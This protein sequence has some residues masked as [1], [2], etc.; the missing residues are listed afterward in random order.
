MPAEEP[1]VD[2]PDHLEAWLRQIE[3]EPQPPATGDW[4][5]R[6][7]P[8]N[9]VAAP[10]LE[11]RTGV[12]VRIPNTQTYDVTHVA[13]VRRRLTH[14]LAA[15]TIGLILLLGAIVTAPASIDASLQIWSAIDDQFT[16]PVPPPLPPRPKLAKPAPLRLPA[17]P[18]DALA[19][20]IR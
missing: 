2:L 17:P 15:L 4:R 3:R 16:P 13:R 1:A 18:P 12:R 20:A 14:R 9:A 5:Q 10:P 11:R 19:P 6:W 7:T 8:T